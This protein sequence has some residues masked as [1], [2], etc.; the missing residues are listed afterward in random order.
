[1]RE[2]EYKNGDLSEFV[3]A[4][5]PALVRPRCMECSLYPFF[6]FVKLRFFS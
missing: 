5:P 4:W 2:E 6:F 3:N 1:M